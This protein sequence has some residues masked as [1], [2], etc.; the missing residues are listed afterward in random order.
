MPL[1]VARALAAVLLFA[2]PPTLA[3]SEAVEVLNLTTFRG[4]SGDTTWPPATTPMA[5][6]IVVGEQI[7]GATRVGLFLLPT[8]PAQYQAPTDFRDAFPE[9]GSGLASSG[10]LVHDPESGR[11]YGV[12]LVTS[13]LSRGPGLLYRAESD[14]AFAEKIADLNQPNGVLLIQGRTLYGL[15]RTPQGQGQLFAL[16]LDD[17]QAS[18]R[19]VHT[20]SAD[21][22][23]FPQHLNGLIAGDDGLLYGLIAYQ[24][25]IP[26]MAGTPSAPDTPTGALYRLDPRQPDSFEIVHTFTLAQ[27]EL[28]WTY[29]TAIRCYFTNADELLAW[30]VLGPDGYLYGTTSVANCNAKGIS[31]DPNHSQY[32]MVLPLCGGRLEATS[33]PERYLGPPPYYDGGIL[34]GAVYRVRPDGSDFTLVHRFSGDD[35][36]LPRGPLAVGA[37]GLIY[38]TTYSGGQSG[39]PQSADYDPAAPGTPARAY[40]GTL[41]R[42]DPQAIEVQDGTVVE[43]GFEFL[44]SFVSEVDG[45]FP[46]GVTA[47][48]DGQLYGANSNGGERYV[49]QAG[50]EQKGQGTVFQVNLD[51]SA[52]RARVTVTTTPVE[53]EK[54]ESATVIWTTQNA[55]NCVGSGGYQGDGWSGARA[56]A[57]ELTVSPPEA[58]IYHY[59]LTCENALTGGQ[60]AGSVTLGVGGLDRDKDGN[61]VEY[62]NGS[63]GGLGPLLLAG[64]ALLLGRRRGRS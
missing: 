3:A 1:V 7:H 5:P 30:L 58:D 39:V 46:V 48:N 4:S 10:P 37:D 40:G 29:C 2:L 18:P 16:D 14:G 62:G 47:G 19:I 21:L 32:R 23:A 60:V 27:G 44:H 26:Y 11:F 51:P 42:I 35:G 59:T 50:K 9:F 33:H 6:P 53:I 45:A 28:P 54:G 61:S 20:F 13:A 55:L 49:N 57:G 17:A 52:P 56:D 15:D 36:V 12:G 63:G 8:Y 38:G 34:Y 25:G 41:Y 22:S 43:N 31:D 24:R 64:L